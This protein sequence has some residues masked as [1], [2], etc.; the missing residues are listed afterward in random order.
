MCY[1]IN[2][3]I[4]SPINYGTIFAVSINK[5]NIICNKYIR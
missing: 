5:I 1:Y 2:F 3:V 4:V